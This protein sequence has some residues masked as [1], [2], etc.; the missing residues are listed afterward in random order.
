M[1]S[2]TALRQN[3]NA[4]AS[5][6]KK[7]CRGVK[8]NFLSFEVAI[9]TNVGVAHI[10][11]LGSREAIAREKGSYPLQFGAQF[12]GGANQ[13]FILEPWKYGTLLKP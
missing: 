3:F 5:R 12:T 6:L 8:S 13:T 4:P 9:I 1:L 7:S 10:E 11:F 2:H